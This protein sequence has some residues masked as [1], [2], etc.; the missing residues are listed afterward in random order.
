MCFPQQAS[1]IHSF[2]DFSMPTSRESRIGMIQLS[3]IQPEHVHYN[4]KFRQGFVV[5]PPA[6]AISPTISSR[7]DEGI[8]LS[9]FSPCR[10]QQL[11]CSPPS[12]QSS[13]V[14][15]N[16]ERAILPI[17]STN[18]SDRHTVSTLAERH[19]PIAASS[20]VEIRRN[21]SSRNRNLHSNI[22]HRLRPNAY[23]R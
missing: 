12:D 21:G 19:D 5:V 23:Q 6:V 3:P 1:D 10:K 11:G 18:S 22:P 20:T 8:L 15:S 2:T 7:N 4:L 17:R 13:H 9:A 14:G 16:T